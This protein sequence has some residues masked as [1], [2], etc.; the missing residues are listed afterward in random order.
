MGLGRPLQTQKKKFTFGLTNKK[1][2]NTS[3][4]QRNKRLLM[5]LTY[6]RHKA[7]TGRIFGVGYNDL[8]KGSSKRP[9]YKRWSS[10]LQRCYAA[11]VTQPT[12]ALCYVCVRWQYLS[13]FVEWMDTQDW[14]GKQL[15][16]D[17][18]GDTF[19]YSPE[20]CC[21]ISRELNTLI[22]PRGSDVIKTEE[23]IS[24]IIRCMEAESDPRV[25]EA[26]KA[27]Y[28]I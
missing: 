2:Y 9:E 18:L 19:E 14:Q 12:Y 24:K 5:M 15:D 25:L 10:M 16:K 22:E 1:K 17:L 23:H 20:K 4:Y 7:E 8:P 6:K 13:N 3:Y 28:G 27:R 11:R 26:L 21:F